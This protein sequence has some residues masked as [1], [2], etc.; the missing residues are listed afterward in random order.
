VGPPRASRD[1]AGSDKAGKDDIEGTGGEIEDKGVED[2]D[3]ESDSDDWSEFDNSDDD[4]HALVRTIS[5]RPFAT[6]SEGVEPKRSTSELETGNAGDYFHFEHS[7]SVIVAVDESLRVVEIEQR[8]IEEGKKDV[9]V[10]V[11]VAS[12]VMTPPTSPD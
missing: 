12:E 11:T 1:I 5:G 3:T 8:V 2:E 6:H 9:V 7:E 10:S 4:N